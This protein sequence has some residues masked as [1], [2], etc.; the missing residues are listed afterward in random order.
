VAMVVFARPDTTARVLEAVRRARPA[1]LLV[2]G[3]A[4]RSGDPEEA[5]RCRQ[6][7][8]LMETVDWD[9]EVSTDYASEHLSM[10]RRFETG[11]G[12]VF[13]EV[14][15]A[16]VL[17]DDCVPDPTFFPFCDALL[18][19]Y[20][21]EERV[22][23]IGGSNVQ[24]DAPTGPDSY[25]FS[26][27]PAIWGWA[28][29]R[30][31]WDAYDPGMSA[32]PELRDGGWVEREFSDPQAV[33]YWRHQFEQTYRG[34]EAWDRAF[35]FAAMAAGR[36]HA[37][38]SVNLVSNVGFREDA[39]HTGPEQRGVLNDLP[40]TPMELPLRHPAAIRRDERADAV[41]ERVA[42]SGVLDQLF[43]R[44]RAKVRAGQ[45]RR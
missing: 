32:W 16:I 24:P 11:L 30:R 19:H 20:R 40:T 43:D 9:C 28:S 14:P 37:V 41:T 26:R 27:Y 8:E 38:S 6:V 10:R 4:P 42:F 44:L 13:S 1:R 15:E 33:A 12:W 21:D 23:S 36:L 2:I 34:D 17:E 7:R 45:D 39:T 22:M 25:Y 29:W 31:A 18:E 5:K 3:N 35:L